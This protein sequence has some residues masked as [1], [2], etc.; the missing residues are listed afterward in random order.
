MDIAYNSDEAY[1]LAR[2]LS[3]FI[4]YFGTLQ[5]M[6]LAQEKGV[7]PL[8]DPDKVDL[9]Y[10]MRLLNDPE[11]SPRKFEEDEVK[12]IGFRNVAITSVAPTGSIALLAGVNSSIEPFFALAYKRNITEGVGNTAKDSIIEINPILF[13]KLEKDNF[14]EE[15]IEELKKFILKNGTLKD[16]PEIFEFYKSPFTT[17]SEI[18]PIWHV[19]M[20][21]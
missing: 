1:K 18:D 4:S 17:A 10:T 2:K 20:Q 7:F 16:A 6:A 9:T 12:K 3:W 14:S 15:Q 13:R 5:S 21:S 8:Y 11:F 19:R